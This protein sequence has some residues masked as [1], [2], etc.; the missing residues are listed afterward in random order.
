[1]GRKWFS[2]WETGR[3]VVDNDKVIVNPEKS[4]SPSLVRNMFLVSTHSPLF[5][6]PWPLSSHC[7]EFV[8]FVHAVALFLM[9]PSFRHV[10]RSTFES[11]IV[12]C[13]SS[14]YFLISSHRVPSYNYIYIIIVDSSCCLSANF[15]L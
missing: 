6:T 10:P 4:F 11:L 15:M 5:M 8:V 3:K 7:I 12:C 14:V 1:M 9:V 13:L 2:V